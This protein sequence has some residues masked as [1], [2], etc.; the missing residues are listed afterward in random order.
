MIGVS[1]AVF[2]VYRDPLVTHTFKPFSSTKVSTSKSLTLSPGRLSDDQS[3][4]S[5][6]HSWVH[7]C[8]YLLWLVSLVALVTLIFSVEHFKDIIAEVLEIESPDAHSLYETY[9]YPV[10]LA[11][12]TTC[13]VVAAW[14]MYSLTHRALTFH[15]AL[16]VTLLPL[17]HLALVGA[18]SVY[19]FIM[20]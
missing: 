14:T 2:H 11:I 5:A 20:K 6:S 18:A 12:V 7:I 16:L 1:I 8:V 10:Y 17:C 19:F 3:T 13:L 15:K 9:G 4:H